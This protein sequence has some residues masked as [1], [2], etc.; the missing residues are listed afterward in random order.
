MAGFFNG[1]D[2]GLNTERCV[3]L[4]LLKKDRSLRNLEFRNASLTTSGS[5]LL[6]AS[7]SNFSEI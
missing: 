1:F 7:D 6:L 2:G 4:S 5:F 3:S